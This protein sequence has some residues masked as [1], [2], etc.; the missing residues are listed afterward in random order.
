MEKTNSKVLCELR[1]VNKSFPLPTGTNQVILRDIDLCIYAEEVVALLGPSGCGKSTLLRIL[2]GLIPPTSGEVLVHSQPLAGMN[3]AVAMVFQ[4]FALYPWMTVQENVEEGIRAAITDESARKQRV[5]EVINKVGLS[6]HED[7]YPR[8]LSGGMKQRVGI[9]RA[10]GF[11]P[12]ILCMDEAFSA[13]DPLTAEG[14]RTEVLDIWRNRRNNPQTV[15]M[16]S[17]DIREVVFMADRIV[18]MGANPGTIRQVLLNNLPR[19][20]DYRSP[21]FLLMVDRVHDLLTQTFLPDA[22]PAPSG[23]APV[24]EPLPHAAPSEIL[25]LVETLAGYGGQMDLFELT[26]R[27][28]QEFGHLTQIVLAAEILDFVDTPRRLVVLTPQGHELVRA[29][30]PGQQRLFRTQMMNVRL[31]QTV[32]AMLERAG[33]VDRDD[34]LDHLAIHLPNQNPEQVLKTLLQWGRF[35]DLISYDETTQE[36]RLA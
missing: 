22:A 6:G 14:L 19:P 11:M 24:L 30:A 20:R 35:A 1:Q 4:N 29:D 7:A 3:P 15:F 32:M 23:A 2:T 17:H 36:V 21:M 27:A 34:L 16:V 26:A 8:E 5:C 18:I 10:L 31:V 9:A 33:R 13:L 12:E 28:R 25:G